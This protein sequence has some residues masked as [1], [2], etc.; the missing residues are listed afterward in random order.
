[1]RKPGP[2]T[3]VEDLIRSAEA[4]HPK[5]MADDDDGRRVI[6]LVLGFSE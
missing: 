5:A 4:A 2:I 1:M 6:H 3:P